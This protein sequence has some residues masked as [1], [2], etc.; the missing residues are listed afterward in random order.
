[1]FM[2]RKNKLFSDVIYDILVNT[3]LTLVILIIL[4][5]LIY[6]IS[7][8]LSDPLKIITGEIWLLPKGF[9]LSSYRKVFAHKDIWVGY[10][11]TVF[12]TGVGTIINL[13]LT[14]LAAY[15]LS[16]SDLKG[17]NVIMGFILLTMYFSGGLVPTYMVV[18]NLG[19]VNSI[20]AILIPNA[21]NTFNLIVTRTFFQSTIPME[22]QEA[23][24]I[25]GCSNTRLFISVILPLSGPILAV[26]A[27]YYGVQ[28]WNDYFSALI[29]VS[30]RKL[31]PLQLILREILLQSEVNEMAT[32]DRGIIE[33]ILQVEGLKYAIIL[34][35]SFP[36]LILYPFLQRYFVKGVMVGSIKG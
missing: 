23:A 29:Y 4:Y 16:R 28:H 5:P 34:I 36:M 26:M 9:T 2:I 27:L 15:S 24:F 25:D 7:C 14:V 12:Y 11:N 8:S 33:R 18:R 3:I 10:R 20:W 31:F 6:V 21:V 1:M 13:F 32:L 17:R 30:N 22:L 35:A 19:M